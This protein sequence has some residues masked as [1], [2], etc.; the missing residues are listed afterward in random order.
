MGKRVTNRAIAL[1]FSLIFTKGC[2]T[3]KEELL[4]DLGFR[5]FV[6]VRVSLR[7]T[8]VWSVLPVPGSIRN[9]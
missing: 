8:S 2:C 1:F 7:A 9:T 6:E 4:S 3:I 5:G